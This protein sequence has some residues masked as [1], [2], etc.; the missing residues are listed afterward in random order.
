MKD[1]DILRLQKQIKEIVDKI[2][3]PAEK[4]FDF[5][6]G[7]MPE[8]TVNKIRNYIK[9]QKLWVHHLPK[10]YGGLGLDLIDTCL[11]FSEMGRSPIAPYMFNCDAPDEGN[12][13]LLIESATESQKEKYLYPLIEGKIRSA[14]AMTEPV[15]GAG[16]DPSSLQT[17]AI[18]DGQNYIINGHKW[19]CTGANGASFVIIFSKFEN[20]FRKSS[21]FIVP[22]DVE[23]YEMLREIDVMGSHGPG[24][25]CELLFKNVKVPPENVLGKIG[26]GFRLTQ[27]RL[28][29]A[30]LTHCMRWIGLARRAVEIARDYA[31]KR[32]L[33]SKKLAE[34]QGIQWMFSESVVEIEAAYTLTMNAAKKITE[35]KD[36]RKEVSIA[37]YYTAEMLNRV[38]DRSMQI[39]GS[40]GYS[41]DLPLEW[42]Y[43]DARAARYA[44]GSSEL[45]KMVIAR[46]ILYGLEKD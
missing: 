26:Q 5:Q 2:I 3:I 7:R 32:N 36:A 37:K 30:R 27:V 28:G 18:F 33:F 4:E 31:F 45:H 25:H 17:N 23:G 11:I 15:P 14:F 19:F 8:T 10:E 43:R 13:H 20:S 40:Y 29:P 21:L 35:G 38:I 34:H 41:R 22:T 6:T 16:S 44:D 46:I 39:C 9:D 12:M 1:Y 24:G 42:F